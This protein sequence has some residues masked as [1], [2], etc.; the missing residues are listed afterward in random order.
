MEQPKQANTVNG[1]ELRGLIGFGGTSL[2]MAAVQQRLAQR[3]QVERKV[4]LKFIWDQGRAQDEVERLVRLDGNRGVS[5]LIDYF[6]L[7][8]QD[9]QHLLGPA[10]EKRRE[11]TG[12]QLTFPPDKLIA[13][14][15]LQFAYGQ[16]IV[17]TLPLPHGFRHPAKHEWL[18]EIDGQ[19]HLQSLA[20]KLSVHEKIALVRS[21]I[22]AIKG[23]HD[24]QPA[25]V[26]GDIHPGNVIFDRAEGE[27]IVIDWGGKEVYGTDGWLSPWH[28]QLILGEI[29]ALPEVVDIY[30]LALWIQRLL[31]DER[32]AWHNLAANV[33][34]DLANGKA[35]TIGELLTRFEDTYQKI[36][37]Q[38]TRTKILVAAVTVLAMFAV[39]LFWHGPAWK[40]AT[41]QRDE[42]E[43]L[44]SHALEDE[45]FSRTGLD[46]LQAHLKDPEYQFLEDDIINAIGT[47]KLHYNTSAPFLATLDLAKPSCVFISQNLSFV[48]YR[49]FPFSVGSSVSD[50]EFIAKV[51]AAGIL[52]KQ[53]TTFAE[54][55]VGF[56]D[57][58]LPLANTRNGQLIIYES[59]LREVMVALGTL[60]GKNVIYLPAGTPRIFGILHGPHPEALLK[61]ICTRIGTSYPDGDVI[62]INTARDWTRCWEM[63]HPHRGQAS[64]DQLFNVYLKNYLH[65]R[66]PPLPDELAAVSVELPANQ[67]FDILQLLQAK[68]AGLGYALKADPSGTEILLAS[69]P[70]AK[71]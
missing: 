18:I 70:R 51:T 27:A 44:L 3:F 22:K 30:L 46:L 8:Y 37:E 9:A 23:A 24:R 55:F 39:F 35:I 59:D 34:A 42:V 11:K 13:V 67:S 47:I 53:R 63:H 33:L 32:A 64:F 5:G 14:L 54:R 19:P 66:T 57:F 65:Y 69:S 26:H 71:E 29:Q 56:Q 48:A 10:L 20:V 12:E 6:E 2:V 58:P 40:K 25:Q 1:Y 28:D 38:R 4:A 52:L 16:M 43:D 45:A 49:Q 50:D 7:T 17:K 21:L 36:M 68:A 41:K 61:N 60:V 62:A 31:G 15:V